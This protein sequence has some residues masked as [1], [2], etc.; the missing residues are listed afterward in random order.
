MR[1]SRLVIMA[2]VGATIAEAQIPPAIEFRV[3]N[4]PTLAAGDSVGGNHMVVD[5]GNGHF[6]FYAHLQPGSL[7]VL[8]DGLAAGT[9]TLGA[10]GLPASVSAFDLLGR[11]QLSNAGI[12]CSRAAP[13]T[14]RNA[15][16]LQNQL[17][18]FPH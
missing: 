15:I 3:P 13:M 8:V 1:M 2:L 5:I 14:V 6:A 12:R 16:P 10:E 4:P 7:R 11:C 18:R 9:S 17:V